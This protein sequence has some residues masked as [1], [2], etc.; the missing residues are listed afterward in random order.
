VSCDRVWLLAETPVEDLQRHG[1]ERYPT[2]EQ[3]CGAIAYISGQRPGPKNRVE[4]FRHPA[5]VTR[6]TTEDASGLTDTEVVSVLDETRF[7]QIILTYPRGH[8]LTTNSIDPAESTEVS[9]R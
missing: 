6:K 1:L 8:H 5:T 4:R 9:G 3:A 7:P 2:A